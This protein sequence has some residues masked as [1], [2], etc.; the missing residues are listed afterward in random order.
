MTASAFLDIYGRI[1]H[2]G[3]KSSPIIGC[4]TTLVKSTLSPGKVFTASADSQM[5]T[6][7]LMFHEMQLSILST[8][9][10]LENPS[11]SNIQ[12][13]IPFQIRITFQRPSSPLFSFYMHVLHCTARFTV[14]SANTDTQHLDS[15]SYHMLLC[16]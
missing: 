16:H 3:L 4:F 2:P 5:A 10:T 15:L 7:L 13:R 6:H 1:G 9:L 11:K 14:K 12:L 8:E